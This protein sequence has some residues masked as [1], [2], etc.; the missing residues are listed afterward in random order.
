MAHKLPSRLADDL[1][2]NGRRAIEVLRR[3]Q[4][5]EAIA[6]GIAQMHAGEMVPLEE[7][8][9]QTRQELLSRT[10]TTE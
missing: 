4:D 5:R 2:A 6:A 7:A 8:R 9:R 1:N 3:L 10:P